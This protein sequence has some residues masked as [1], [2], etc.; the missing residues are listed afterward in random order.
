M[1]KSTVEPECTGQF[2]PLFLDYIRQK[3]N[4]RPFYNAF[5]TL[6]N[7]RD[8]IE[9]RTFE[10]EKRKVLA[11]ALRRQYKGYTLSEVTE[12]HL[13]RLEGEKTYTVT[14]GHQ[15]NL[16]TGPLYFI[17]KIVST[18]N[19][20]EKLQQAY[21][22]H[23][24]VPVYWMASEDH[25]FDEINYFHYEGKKY[26]W[27]TD[28]LGAVGDFELDGTMEAF[29][30]ELVFAP[31]F[32]K[33]AYKE[34]KTLSEAVRYYVNHLF[35]EKGLVIVDGHDKAL[36]EI[37]KPVI[38]DDLLTNKAN[39]LVNQQ[40]QKLESLGYKSQI[41]PREINFFYL[42]KGIRS[43]IVKSGDAYEILDNGKKFSEE[44]MLQLVEE[45]PELFS[46]NVVLRPLYQECIL[47]NVA[48]LGGPAEV[49]YWLQ[50]K[51]VFDHYGT[52]YPMVM[53]R[54]FALIKDTKAGRKA[55]ALGLS[56]EQLFV[57]YQEWKKEYVK[58][59]SSHDLELSE[60]KKA[61]AAIF[62][63]LGEEAAEIDPTLKQSSESAKVR[64]MKVLEH[65]GK[66]LRRGEERNMETALRRMEELKSL[67]FPSGVPQERKNN[68]L[69]FFLA[70]EQFIHELYPLFDPLD[71][72]YIIL[73]KD[74]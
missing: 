5:P 16:F 30:R 37:L 60:Q 26:S 19:L 67:L 35:G 6:E 42:D 49:V 71:F 22:E 23:H 12:R 41:Y 51:P 54:N 57:D 55:K 74:E 20:A 45:R 4:L 68:F 31:E 52:D 63:Q 39:E 32:F 65:F 2:S 1:L 46:P 7:F 21:P 56:D 29:L 3:E 66:K 36:K 24:F 10:T 40:T 34:H 48:Y 15:L 69:E 70:D 14:T 43:R 17:Y 73:E 50:L 28:Q 18:I 61:L 58:Q 27:N 38:K 72:S 25:D 11:A 47:P 8:L 64:A 9:K 59:Q 53:P 62:E 33:K 13:E 44:E